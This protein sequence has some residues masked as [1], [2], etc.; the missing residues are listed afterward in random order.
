MEYLAGILSG[1]RRASTMLMP[2]STRERV[3][4]L[5]HPRRQSIL[6]RLPEEACGGENTHSSAQAVT[7]DVKRLQLAFEVAAGTF[8]VHDVFLLPC[9]RETF[10]HVVP[11]RLNVCVKPRVHVAAGERPLHGFRHPTGC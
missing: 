5:E 11:E 8:V 1:D 2:T 7:G 3:H 6:E 10:D 9:R 4:A